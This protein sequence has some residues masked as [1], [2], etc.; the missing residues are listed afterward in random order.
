MAD[1]LTRAASSFLEK[2]TS[3]R[4]FLTRAAMAGSALAVGPIRY[5]VRPES[6]WAVIQPGSCASGNCTI[7]F[8]EFCCSL[9]GNEGRNGCPPGTFVGG[10]WKANP[11]TGNRFCHGRARYYLDCNVRRQSRCTNRP[12]C[13]RNNC[14]CFRTCEIFF[15]YFNCN[16]HLQHGRRSWVVCRMVMCTNPCQ[17]KGPPN[18]DPRDP[19]GRCNCTLKT[20][21]ETAFAEPCLHRGDCR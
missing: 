1:R 9:R 11:P 21:P 13:A 18:P 8:T 5:L 7:G 20:D 6:A 15:S 12:G 17:L 4:G 2:R 10:W 16:T 3:R 19:V 14:H